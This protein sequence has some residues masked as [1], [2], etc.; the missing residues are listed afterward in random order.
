MKITCLTDKYLEYRA[1]VL[2][3]QLYENT[4]PVLFSHYY[5]F[6]ADRKYPLSILTKD[7]II[8]RLETIIKQIQLNETAFYAA[9]IDISELEIVLFVGI[10][11]SNGH[12]FHD[13]GKFIVWIPIETYHT[14]MLAKVFLTHEIIH[15]LHYENVPAFY[16]HSHK[17]KERL[18]RQLITEGVASYLSGKILGLDD[19]L[20]LWADYLA[21]DDLDKWLQE[22]A[23]RETELYKFC[24]ENFSET[25]RAADLFRIV[26]RDNIM[27]FRVGYYLGLNLV[28]QI[29]EGEKMTPSELLKIERPVFEELIYKQLQSLIA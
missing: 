1:G 22:C 2:D 12:A 19:R 15:A 20:A 24:L 5:T 29:V 21:P 16:F 18:S 13:R 17:E 3:R 10:N 8:A 28:R 25:E 23:R 4:Y 14:P 7:D 11:S 27:R 9:G 26:E 6:W